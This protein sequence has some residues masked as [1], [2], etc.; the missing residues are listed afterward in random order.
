MY[1]MASGHVASF[2]YKLISLV[3]QEV[4]DCV[5]PCVQLCT[6]PTHWSYLLKDMWAG[7]IFS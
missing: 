5:S 1:H 3:A 4:A 6:K 7:F 2:F